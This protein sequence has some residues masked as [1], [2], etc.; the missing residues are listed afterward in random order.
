MTPRGRALSAG[1][2][3]A[4]FP[5]ARAAGVRQRAADRRRRARGCASRCRWNSTTSTCGCSTTATAGC[6][7]TPAWPRT[8]AAQA[9][10]ELEQHVLDGRPLRRIFVTH[11]HPDHMGLAPWLAERHGAAVWMSEHAHRSSGEFLRTEPAALEAARARGSCAGTAW[12]CAEGDS[13]A[14]RPSRVV[15]RLAGARARPG[16]RRR[17]RGGQGTLA[18]DRDRRPLPRAPVPARR[19]APPAGERRPG[20]ADH[21]AERERAVVRRPTPTRCGSSSP[22]SS[23]CA[24]APRTRWCCPRTAG[25]SAACTRVSPTSRR[26]TASSSTRCATPARS[27]ARPSSCCRPCSA[28][29]RAASTGCS[30]SARRS[31]TSTTCARGDPGAP[32]GRQRG[33]PVRRLPPR[34][35]RRLTSAG[36]RCRGSAR[37]GYP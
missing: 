13:A 10:L 18:G 2:A 28:A 9:W 1:A 21:L 30:R 29:C 24:R 22:R 5:A 35:G 15:R 20:A 17:G 25:R 4:R 31:R 32:G 11:D 34:I 26:T 27:H 16:R 6:W 3:Q 19:G 23:G 8:S 37:L 7:S 14:R 33:R 36:P 12:R